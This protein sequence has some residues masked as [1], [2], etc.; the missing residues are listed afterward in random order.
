MGRGKV[1][2]CGGHSVL[3]YLVSYSLSVFSR[4]SWARQES[5]WIWRSSKKGIPRPISTMLHI[6]TM[7]AM[8]P[9]HIPLISFLGETPC[10]LV[11]RRHSRS[12]ASARKTSPRCKPPFFHCL[13]IC[14]DGKSRAIYQ[15]GFNV[16]LP[17]P[18]RNW[19]LGRDGNTP[20]PALLTEHH[21]ATH[22]YGSSDTNRAETIVSSGTVDAPGLLYVRLKTSQNA[23]AYT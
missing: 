10:E 9:H 5:I 18:P 1:H 7:T 16:P 21:R 13:I 14:I 17:T 3:V 15:V 22:T 20:F 11:F 19:P 2:G 23:M 12:P 4:R 8:P 6:C